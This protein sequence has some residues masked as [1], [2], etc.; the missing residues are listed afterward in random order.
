MPNIK[1]LKDIINAYII[2]RLP[3]KPNVNIDCN[4]DLD[5]NE[6]NNCKV[7]NVAKAYYFR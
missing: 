2:Y 5:K 6:C 4:I 7:V 1:Q 3:N